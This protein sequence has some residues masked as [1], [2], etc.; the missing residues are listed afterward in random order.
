MDSTIAE[1]AEAVNDV[2]SFIV[3]D[4]D[5]EVTAIEASDHQA[6]LEAVIHLMIHAR[7]VAGM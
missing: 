7:D 2:D 5:G 6:F 3:F 4:D 1:L